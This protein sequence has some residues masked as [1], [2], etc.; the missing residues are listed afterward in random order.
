MEAAEEVCSG[1]EIENYEVLDLL[2]HLVDKSLVLVEEEQDLARYRLL[3][4]IRQYASEKLQA[5]D[6]HQV[7]GRKHRDHFLQMVVEAEPELV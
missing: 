4:T 5:S 3:G 6:E 1:E 7:V 2:F